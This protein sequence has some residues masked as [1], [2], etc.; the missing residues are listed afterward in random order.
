[1][2]YEKSCGAVIY[3]NNGGIEY[4]LIENKKGDAPG[5]WGFPKGH[6]D[7]GETE[8]ETALREITEET[9]LR[10]S[11]I[12]SF[13]YIE[14]YCPKDDITKDAVYFLAEASNHDVTIQQSEIANYVWTSYSDAQSRL[15]YDADR[16]L[17]TYANMY[18]QAYIENS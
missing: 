6:M 10:V 7:Q 13:R 3:R 1:M 4:L 17:L 2:K 5:H 18:R 16:T 9:G 15:T 12:G 11:L 8:H 14:R